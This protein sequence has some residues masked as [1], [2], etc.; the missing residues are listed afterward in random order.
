MDPIAFGSWFGL[1]WFGAKQAS[2]G[3][4]DPRSC[5]RSVS[6]SSRPVRLP[7]RKPRS[8]EVIKDSV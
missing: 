2:Y 4:L 5:S 8:H 3:W 6:S 1:F 7:R